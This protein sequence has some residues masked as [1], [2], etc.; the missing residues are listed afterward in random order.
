MRIIRFLLMSSVIA[1]SHLVLA[2]DATLSDSQ[3]DQLFKG[4]S[5]DQVPPGQI[6]FKN[7]NIPV[8]SNCADT[9][10]LS[11][12]GQCT[13]CKSYEMGATPQ[14]TNVIPFPEGKTYKYTVQSLSTTG[15]QTSAVH[16]GFDGKNGQYDLRCDPPS[17]PKKNGLKDFV[18][19]LKAIGIQMKFS[20]P[21]EANL[22]AAPTNGNGATAVN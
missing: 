14:Q 3:A 4:Y 21:Q 13:L 2:A 15:A 16:L 5:Y 11:S 22:I 18:A 10:Q 7:W 12:G 8:G 9:K 6:S 20:K 17:D 19:D 1:A